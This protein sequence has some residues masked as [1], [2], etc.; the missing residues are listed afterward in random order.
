MD[1]SKS[2]LLIITESFNLESYK[3]RIIEIFINLEKH[4]KGINFISST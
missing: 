2:N 4:T 3:A 1:K